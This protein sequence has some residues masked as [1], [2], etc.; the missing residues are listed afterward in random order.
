[1][2]LNRDFF[3]STILQQDKVLLSHSALVISSIPQPGGENLTGL[4]QDL[5]GAKKK[6][7]CSA[8]LSGAERPRIS[9]S[10]MPCTRL[11]FLLSQDFP[12]IMENHL[13]KTLNLG[14]PW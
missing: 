8:Q 1:M 13:W 12:K 5:T 6:I 11:V 4:V 10:P 14:Q 3:V 9:I 7:L 2:M